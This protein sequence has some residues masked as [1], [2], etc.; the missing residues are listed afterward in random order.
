MLLR[1]M[2]RRSLKRKMSISRGAMPRF[3][4]LFFSDSVNLSV[5]SL[6]VLSFLFVF[7]VI[8]NPSFWR[9]SHT[10]SRNQISS[11]SN[12]EPFYTMNQQARIKLLG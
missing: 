11:I 2:L 12:S 7:P 5:L 8:Y 1:L 9:T 4:S 6:F 3:Q 10:H